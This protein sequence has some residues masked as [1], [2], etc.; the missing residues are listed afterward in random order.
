[1][2][3]RFL[4]SLFVL[5]GICLCSCRPVGIVEL[6]RADAQRCY[7]ILARDGELLTSLASTLDDL[8]ANQPDSGAKLLEARAQCRAH[9]T[10]WDQLVSELYQKYGLSEEAYRL[11]VFRGRFMRRGMG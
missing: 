7:N 2:L 9:L 3:S 11:D 1:M 5:G 10:D 4:L 6:S 8:A